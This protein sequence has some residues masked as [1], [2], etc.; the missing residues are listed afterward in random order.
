MNRSL[1]KL[2]ISEVHYEYIFRAE[3]WGLGFFQNVGNHLPDWTACDAAI[4]IFILSVMKVHKVPWSVG[5]VG[6]KYSKRQA[7]R[8]LPKVPF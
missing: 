5:P 1:G 2:H 4:Y 8:Y 6:V 3:D 7:A